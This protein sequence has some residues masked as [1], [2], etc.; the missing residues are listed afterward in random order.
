MGGEWLAD[1]KDGT[2]STGR[3]SLL[4]VCSEQRGDGGIVGW[5]EAETVIEI[6][7][8]EPA[9]GGIAKAAV[10]VVDDEETIA[11]LGGGLGGTGLA[12]RIHYQEGCGREWGRCKRGGRGW[13]VNR[14]WSGRDSIL[15]RR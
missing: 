10:A 11:E 9:D 14:G 12:G 2:G 4:G 8:E 13:K 6:A 5:G 3:V 7:P 15:A 1:A